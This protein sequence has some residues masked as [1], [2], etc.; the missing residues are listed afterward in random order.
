MSFVGESRKNYSSPYEVC[1]CL[2]VEDCRMIKG[3]I[4]SLLKR[5]QMASQALDEVHEGGEATEAQETARYKAHD[6]VD[7][8]QGILDDITEVIKLKGGQQ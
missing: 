2:D 1:V 3:V 4:N 8:V 5:K 6:R 7:R